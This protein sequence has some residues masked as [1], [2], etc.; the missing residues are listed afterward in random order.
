MSKKSVILTILIMSFVFTSAFA[1][2]DDLTGTWEQTDSWGARAG[3]SEHK[4]E[5]G[6]NWTTLQ[7]A[8]FELRINEQSP[9]KRAFHGEWCSPNKCEDLVGAIMSDGTL[10][11]ADEDGYFEGKVIGNN[12]ELCYIE[13]DE[14]MRVVNCRFMKKK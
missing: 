1:F 3:K 13:A 11:M 14:N 2:A 6:D 8:D 9:D 7:K 10:Y 4:L 5:H 12:M